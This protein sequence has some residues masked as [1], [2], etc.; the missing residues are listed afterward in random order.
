[1]MM[2][3]LYFKPIFSRKDLVSEN[4]KDIAMLTVSFTVLLKHWMLRPDTGKI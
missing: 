3:I 4:L 1:M 2:M